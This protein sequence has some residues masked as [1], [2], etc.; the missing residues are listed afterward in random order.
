LPMINEHDMAAF[1]ITETHKDMRSITDTYKS[2][3][4]EHAAYTNWTDK[5]KRQEQAVKEMV[6]EASEVMAEFVKS[7]RKGRPVSREK[8]LDELGDTLW[9][10]VGVMN[11]FNMSWHEVMTH[12]MEKLNA[13]Y[14]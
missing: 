4:S 12:N 10:L 3:Q 5:R 13:R 6:C 11:E 7:A 1:G 8:I 14:K 2:W 9:G